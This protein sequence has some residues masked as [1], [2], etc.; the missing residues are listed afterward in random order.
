MSGEMVLRILSVRD[1]DFLEAFYRTH[2][3]TQRNWKTVV[4]TYI[5]TSRYGIK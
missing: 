1:W 2:T 5:C 4:T 3:Q